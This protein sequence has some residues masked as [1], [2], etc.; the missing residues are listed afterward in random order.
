MK[1]Q[2]AHHEAHHEVHHEAHPDYYILVHIEP[3]SFINS[4]E[5]G[6]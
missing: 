1:I 6:S 5:M 3:T 2:E 4:K